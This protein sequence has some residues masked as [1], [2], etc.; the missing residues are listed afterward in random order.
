[1]PLCKLT[2]RISTVGLQ[3]NI[4]CKAEGS[5]HE[6]SFKKHCYLTVELY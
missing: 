3:N 2:Q 1:M 5:V 4:L 6:L